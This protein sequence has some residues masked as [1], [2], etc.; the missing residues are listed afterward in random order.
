MRNLR[1]FILSSSIECNNLKNMPR[2]IQAERT[3]YMY[4]VVCTIILLSLW[5]CF[6]SPLVKTSCHIPYTN[7]FEQNFTQLFRLNLAILVIDTLALL[8]QQAALLLNDLNRKQMVLWC[9]PCPPLGTLKYLFTRLTLYLY[10]EIR[11]FI[12]WREAIFSLLFIQHVEL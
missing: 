3:L 11:I 10:C 8:T 4:C 12:S 1:N 6:H 2:F 9:W 7:L 5:I